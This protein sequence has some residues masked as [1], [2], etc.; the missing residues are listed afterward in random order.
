MWTVRLALL[1]A[2]LAGQCAAGASVGSARLARPRA[3]CTMAGRGS[4]SAEVG[5][6]RRSARVGQVV[7]T[8]LAPLITSGTIHRE[9]SPLKDTIRSMISI[10]DVTVTDDMRTAKVRISTLG[11]KLD[12]LRAIQWLQD[13][14][15]SIRFELAQRLTYM[16]RIPDLTFTDID[17][18]S[19]VRVMALI[20]QLAAERTEDDDG[21]DDEVVADDLDFEFADDVD[22]LDF[23]WADKDA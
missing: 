10:V 6:G 7:R 4:R 11:E 16:R 8:E 2:M 23:D 5:G 21:A 17:I 9:R 15:K 3:A 14:R 22:D 20:S 18:S 1:A 19:P 12:G 13:N